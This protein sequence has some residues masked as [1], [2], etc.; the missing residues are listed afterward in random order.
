MFMS[1]PA[2]L[3]QNNM[4]DMDSPDS[5]SRLVLAW[6]GLVILLLTGCSR[7][8]VPSSKPVVTLNATRDYGYVLGDL[9]PLS[10]SVRLPDGE[11]LDSASLPA[12]GPINE[13][14]SLRSRDIEL[15][16]D[17]DQR[18]AQLH[19]LYQV[20]KGVRNPEL[21][22]IPPLSL[23]TMGQTP[24]SFETPSWSFTLTPVIPP[25]IENDDLDERPPLP[26][27]PASTTKAVNRVLLWVT[28]TMLT[29]ILVVVG[30]FIRRRRTR[31][32]AIAS[33]KLYPLLAKSQ[34]A[35]TLRE[36]IRLL[37]RAFDQTFG[38]TLFAREIDRFCAAHPSFL[39]LRDRLANF[40]MQSNQ[41]FFDPSTIDAHDPA[42]RNWL[43]DLARRCVMAESKAL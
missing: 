31:P 7:E 18:K 13:W 36:A 3:W 43:E 27:E 30:E 42:T 41:L 16:A 17:G 39:P 5:R 10:L 12:T 1:S 32:F 2:R 14:L 34:D 22:T 25:E 15:L 6:G 33:K 28:G 40:F 26:V 19:L 4:T 38:E 29:L 21:A 35:N 20:F 11:S 24:Q 8:T 37:H 9:I 23:R